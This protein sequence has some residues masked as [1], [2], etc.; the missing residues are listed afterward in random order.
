M[1]R[2]KARRIVMNESAKCLSG[3]DVERVV[4]RSSSGRGGTP[5][6][7]AAMKWKQQSAAVTW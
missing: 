3:R 2:A 5:C 6:E 1:A 4:S 7:S